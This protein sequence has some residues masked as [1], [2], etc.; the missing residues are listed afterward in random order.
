MLYLCCC[1]SD[2]AAWA[3]P[4]DI[5][6]STSD[7][8]EVEVKVEALGLSSEECGGQKAGS[9]PLETGEDEA[10]GGLEIGPDSG[11]GRAPRMGAWL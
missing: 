7:I 2:L 5:A 6:G 1:S 10:V 11:R 8:A 3:R 4:G 9:W